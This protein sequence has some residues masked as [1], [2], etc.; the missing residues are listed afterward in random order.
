[1]DPGCGGD[2]WAFAVVLVLTVPAYV[3]GYSFTKLADSADDGLDPTS[4]GCASINDRG[5]VAFRAGRVASDGFNTIPGI[6]R[7]N[8][9]DGSLTTIVEDAK[10]FVTIGFNPSMNDLGQVSFAARVDGRSNQTRNPSCR[11]AGR[12]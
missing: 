1:L 9:A 6:Y 7:V 3:Q 2:R 8:A 10:R 11:E 4:L 12:S 5:D